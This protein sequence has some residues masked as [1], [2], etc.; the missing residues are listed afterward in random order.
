MSIFPVVANILNPGSTYSN[1]QDVQIYDNHLFVSGFTTGGTSTDIY[2]FDLNGNAL[3]NFTIPYTGYLMSYVTSYDSIIIGTGESPVN[4]YN[5]YGG[6]T[7]NFGLPEGVSIASVTDYFDNNGHY[8]YLGV[9][10]NGTYTQP[11]VYKYDDNHEQLIPLTGENQYYNVRVQ[12]YN[13]HVYFNDSLYNFFQYI[14]RID[15]DGSNYTIIQYSYS[16]VDFKIYN[17]LI[18]CINNYG[19]TLQLDL[20]GNQISYIRTFDTDIY[21]PLSSVYFG[22]LQY[23][24][25][26]NKDTTI[27]YLNTYR[28]VQPP[29]IPLPYRYSGTTPSNN[30]LQIPDIPYFDKTNAKNLMLGVE[31]INIIYSTPDTAPPFS[32]RITSSILANYNTYDG[33]TNSNDGLIYK[34]ALTSNTSVTYQN[35]NITSK[36]VGIPLTNFYFAPFIDLS[37]VFTDILGNNSN[38]TISLFEISLVF[39]TYS[40][41]DIKVLTS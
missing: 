41:N 30:V 37:V 9:A 18:Y 16:Y 15:P 13:G 38:V 35:T 3:N 10:P 19:Y 7:F 21:R 26:E 33:T 17:D 23:N 29:I 2:V 40:G 31:Y 4:A 12:Y 20:Q 34:G 24:L 1:V 27:P 6:D 14:I 28:V 22:N 11:T 32:V 25:Y 8:W 5:L 39:Y 36:Y